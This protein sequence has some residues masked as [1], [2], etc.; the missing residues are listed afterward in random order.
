MCANEAG[1]FRL[2]MLDPDALRGINAALIASMCLCPALLCPC[3]CSQQHF[4]LGAVP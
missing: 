2:A 3:S 4:L 1:V